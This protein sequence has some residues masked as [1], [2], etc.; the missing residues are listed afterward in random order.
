[1]TAEAS[2]EPMA[3]RVPRIVI[4]T[5]CMGAGKSTI[6]QA[7]AER[8]PKAVHL[9]GDLFR[10]MIISG[11]VEMSQDPS[12]E[13]ERQ[14]RLRYELAWSV[15]AQYADAGFT[16]VYQDVILGEFL[17]WAA[18]RLGG[19]RPAVVVLDPSAEVLTDR[20]RARMK[21][22]YDDPVYGCWTAGQ[23][24]RVLHEETPHIGLWLDTSAQSVDDTVAEILAHLRQR[25]G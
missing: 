9:R 7:L 4:I 17:G 21:N 6:A 12:P 10:R 24:R 16:V 25:A 18:E 1:V 14:L 3:E 8:L 19:Y 2:R 23:I 22:I 13:A 5:G 20:D 15:A 11:R